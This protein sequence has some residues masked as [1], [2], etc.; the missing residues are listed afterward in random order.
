MEIISRAINPCLSTEITLNLDDGTQKVLAVKEGDFIKE[1][2]FWDNGNLL[3]ISGIL[4]LI[5][6]KSV[7]SDKMM[8]ACEHITQSYFNKCV[9]A[10]AFVVDCSDAYESKILTI[11]LK[12]IMG[13]EGSS[14]SVPEEDGTPV[15]VRQI[16]LVND[17]TTLKWR[18]TDQVEYTDLLAISDIKGD[19]GDKGETGDPFSIAKV[20]P[21]VAD[22]EAD[23]TNV[24]VPVGAFV[25][26]STA[27]VADEDNG[28]LYVKTLV[29]YNFLVDL[30]GANGIVGPQGPQGEQGIQG[31]KGD[32]G[33]QGPQ[34]EK[35]D[36]GY[37]PTVTVNSTPAGVEITTT[38]EQGSTT[39]TVLHGVSP[40][41]DLVETDEGV[42]M[43]VTDASGDH[44]VSIPKGKNAV[45]PVAVLADTAEGHVL[46]ITDASGTTQFTVKDGV[47]AVSPIAV[48]ET[49]DEGATITIT[50]V[51]GTYVTSIKNG[52][53]GKDGIDGAQGP[54]GPQGVQ[55]EKGDSF[56]IAKTY[57]SIAEMYAGYATDGLP[58]GAF[59]LISNETS[60]DNGKLYTKGETQYAYIANLAGVQGIQGPQ[61]IQGIQGIQGP[62]GA[63]GRDGRDGVDGVSATITPLQVVDG[64]E[65]TITDSTGSQTVKLTNGK[66]GT[67]GV[68]AAIVEDSNND[69]TTY[70]LQITDGTGIIKNTPNLIG[71]QGPKGED[72]VDGTDGLTPTIEVDPTNEPGVSYKLIITLGSTTYTTPNLIG[73]KGQDYDPAVLQALQN[74]VTALTARVLALEGAG[75]P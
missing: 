33:E 68:S 30:S 63:N 52:R 49:T 40:T 8:P 70:K 69:S 9:T 13:F 20:Y 25:L 31:E 14:V 41:V 75:T 7:P 66:D 59:V 26:V 57:P 61:G 45:S 5:L 17:G 50:D 23:F 47:D 60:S 65:L 38:F 6:F 56:A 62:S 18:Y 43:T 58:E 36:P 11:P 3:S 48:V 73:P 64:I 28:K 4:K 39:A 24:D 2:S 16:E 32:Q 34:G 54:Q 19:K 27:D 29:D 44:T 1:L 53:D 72:G 15:K 74:E 35:G 22:M 37:S 10:S 71:P 46:T 21:S 55:G 12:N 51:N 42:D 67:N